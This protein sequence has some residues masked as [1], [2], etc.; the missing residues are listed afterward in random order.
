M[1]FVT[2]TAWALIRV[3]HKPTTGRGVAA[4]VIAAGACLTRLT[5]LSFIAPAFVWM[6]LTAP[7]ESRRLMARS[8]VTAAVVGACWL[9]PT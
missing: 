2:L 3:Y 9:R 1:F 8:T 4:G 5:A 7:R 6:I